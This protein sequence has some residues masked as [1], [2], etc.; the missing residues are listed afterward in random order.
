[1]SEVKT[2][3]ITGKI[4]KPS[5]DIPFSKKILGI[6]QQQVKEKLYSELGSKHKAKRFQI[7]ITKIEEEKQS[8]KKDTT[9]KK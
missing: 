5:G 6:K 2:F 7:D 4:K 9:E 3:I 8:S 1:M